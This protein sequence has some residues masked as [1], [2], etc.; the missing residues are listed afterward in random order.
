MKVSHPLFARVFPRVSRAMEAG[1]MAEHRAWLLAPLSGQVIDIGVGTGASFAHY[2]AAVT[3]VLAVE[4]EP[5]LRALAT[6]AARDARVPVVVTSGVAERLP[7]AD[8]SFDAAVATFVLCTVT[9]QDA[10]LREIAR[11]LKPGGMLCFL[12]HVRADSAA[13]V[14]T[15]RILDATIWPHLAAGCHLHRDTTAAVERAGFRIDAMERFMFPPS[16]TPVSF[17]IVGRATRSHV[18]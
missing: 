15:Q 18:A 12:E 17:H 8:A 4:P 5:R 11:V 14:R 3:N 9:S 10:V 6:A 13:L 7:A 1:G 16:R 2:P